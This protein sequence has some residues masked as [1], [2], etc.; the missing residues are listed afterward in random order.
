MAVDTYSNLKTEIANHLDRDDID[1]PIDTFIDLVESY[2]KREVRIRQ[3]LTRANITVDQRY[4]ALPSG[5]L[6]VK[7]FRLLTDPVRLLEYLTPVE[8]TRERIE[9]DRRPRYFTIH[10]QFEFDAKPDDSYTGELVYYDTPTPLDSQNTTNVIL[11]AA[12]ELYLYG[13]L[14]LAEPYLAN[15]ERVIWAQRYADARDKVNDLAI[16]QRHVGPLRARVVGAT[17]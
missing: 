6:E 16:R 9:L 11:D 4:V 13:A 2:H 10:D 17:P 12:P 8:L 5:L 3:M 15:D 1:G 14:A 7:L